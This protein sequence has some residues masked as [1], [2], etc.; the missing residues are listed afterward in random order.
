MFKV[1]VSNLTFYFSSVLIVRKINI[2]RLISMVIRNL[3]ISVNKYCGS[4]RD[5]KFFKLYI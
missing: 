4:L 1:L 5:V 2:L 3:E